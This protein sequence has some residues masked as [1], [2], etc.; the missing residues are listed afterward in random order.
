ML[1]VLLAGR[2]ASARCLHAS[3]EILAPGIAGES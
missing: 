2:E 1:S 3:A